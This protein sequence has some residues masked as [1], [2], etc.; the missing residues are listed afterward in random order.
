MIKYSG[1]TFI[2]NAE[3]VWHAQKTFDKHRKMLACADELTRGTKII[4]LG[5]QMTRAWR[6]LKFVHKQDIIFA[7][8]DCRKEFGL[9]LSTSPATSCREVSRDKILGIPGP[10]V[11]GK[12]VLEWEKLTRHNI[13]VYEIMIL[14]S[15]W[16]FLH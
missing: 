13:Q 2:A 4:F 9:F 16:L 7:R 14:K 5:T 10:F 12:R 15:L 3:H 11:T 8:R 6:T 1:V